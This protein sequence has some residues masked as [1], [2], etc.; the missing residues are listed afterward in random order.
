MATLVGVV[1]GATRRSGPQGTLL[2][3]T[4]AQ[5]PALNVVMNI[6]EDPDGEEVADLAAVAAKEAEERGFPWSIRLR[7]RPDEAIARTADEYGLSC[8][9]EQLFMVMPL[10]GSSASQ[11]QDG[12][13]RVRALRGGESN[14]F[15]EVVGAGFGAP[16]VIISSAYTPA[17]LDAQE[18]TAYLAEIDGVAVAAGLG[19]M[20]EGHVGVINIATLPQY[21]RRGHAQF[22]IERILS[23][24]RVAGAH[25]AYLHTSNETVSLFESIGFRTTEKWTSLTAV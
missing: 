9:S 6:A 8:E 21:R 22:M 17:V 14:D 23:D 19:V 20:A 2:A 3:L 7:G 18:I 24:G 5:I 15:A 1:P 12:P 10:T 4:Q 16:P 25:T 13:V 11:A